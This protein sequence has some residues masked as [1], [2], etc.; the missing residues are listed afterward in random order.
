MSVVC[1][2]LEQAAFE[3]SRDYFS[4]PIAFIRQMI[5]LSVLFIAVI[6]SM[7]GTEISNHLID[8]GKKENWM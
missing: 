7:P 1:K 2:C 3:N 8:L 4:F 5:G 6:D